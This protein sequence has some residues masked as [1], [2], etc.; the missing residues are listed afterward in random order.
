MRINWATRT[1]NGT[2]SHTLAFRTGSGELL[3]PI[4][5][6]PAWTLAAE[7]SEVKL[8]HG[9]SRCKV[10]EAEWLRRAKPASDNHLFRPPN[11]GAPAGLEPAA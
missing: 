2:A 9:T 7:V 4:G 1:R 10:H 6:R 3:I 5:A 11:A 8:E